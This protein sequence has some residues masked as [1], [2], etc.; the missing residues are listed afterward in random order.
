MAVV[1]ILSSLGHVCVCV[2]VCGL[3]YVASEGLCS[4]YIT[5]FCVGLSTSRLTA[6]LEGTHEEESRTSPLCPRQ[7]QDDLINTYGYFLMSL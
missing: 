1:V 2:S 6:Q 5:L 7:G 3:G 4:S